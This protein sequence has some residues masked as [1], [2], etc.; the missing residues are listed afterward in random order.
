MASW[1]DSVRRAVTGKTFR[2]RYTIRPPL[3]RTEVFTSIPMKCGQLAMYDVSEDVHPQIL[4]AVAINRVY[5]CREMGGEFTCSYHAQNALLFVSLVDDHRIVF[6]ALDVE[7][8]VEGPPLVTWVYLHPQW[9]RK[10]VVSDALLYVQ[11]KYGEVSVE[12]PISAGMRSILRK[13]GHPQAERE[14]PSHENKNY[15]GYVSTR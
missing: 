4:R 12:F 14:N 10:G 8:D 3:V 6:G 7:T 9:R 5:F 11:K 15:G 1:Q 2:D 13:M